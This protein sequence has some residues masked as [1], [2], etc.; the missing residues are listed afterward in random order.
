LFLRSD[1]LY[2]SGYAWHSVM[3]AVATSLA[4]IVGALSLVR[5]YSR[6][7]ITFLLIGCG[8]LGAALLDLNHALRSSEW[9]IQVL[10]EIDPDLSVENVFSWSWTAERVFLAMFLFGSLLAWRQEVR[11]DG[12]EVVPEAW[13]YGTALVMTVLNLLF[14]ESVAPTR[15]LAD[16]RWIPGTASRP[17]P[18][19][20]RCPCCALRPSAMSWSPK[21]SLMGEPAST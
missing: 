3:E 20:A 8:F 15:P 9:Y 14:F 10:T 4:F 19:R 2:R 21:P 17:W 7:Q 13:V 16:P 11:G 18:R 6:K 12:A 1:D 5:Y